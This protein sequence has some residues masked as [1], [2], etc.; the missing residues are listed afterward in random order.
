LGVGLLRERAEAKVLGRSAVG[1]D[2]CAGCSAGFD[3][4]ADPGD[5]KG[6]LEDVDVDVENGFE[7]PLEE[8]VENGFAE[9][10]LEFENGFPPNSAAPRS[11]AGFVGCV[12]T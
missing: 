11:T 4:C 10:V 6:L 3:S 12:S 1:D 8:L 2:G 7:G 5:A 9:A